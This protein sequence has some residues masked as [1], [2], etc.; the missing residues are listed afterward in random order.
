MKEYKLF[1]LFGV[2]WFGV[3][4]QADSHSMSIGSMSHT[5]D[6]ISSPA[7]HELHH[8]SQL[9]SKSKYLQFYTLNSVE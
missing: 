2:P 6:A 4:V 9:D 5:T 8:S 7:W 3:M 1:H